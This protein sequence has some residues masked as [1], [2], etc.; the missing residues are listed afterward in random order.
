ME[1]VEEKENCKR[2][3]RK[4]KMEEGKKYEHENE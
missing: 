2:E 4:F 1:N 3:G